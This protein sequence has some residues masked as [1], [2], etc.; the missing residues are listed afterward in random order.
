MLKESGKISKNASIEEAEQALD[1]FLKKK[2]ESLQEKDSSGELED[3]KLEVE[4]DIKEKLKNGNKD[5]AKG[6][7]SNGGKNLA[8]VVEEEY[9]GDVRSDNVLV[10]LAEFPYFPHYTSPPEA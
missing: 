7:Y 4:A 10:L 1:R 2:S 9:D 8:P 5:K 3:E 6:N